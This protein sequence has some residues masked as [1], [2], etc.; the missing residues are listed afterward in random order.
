MA[1]TPM[2]KSKDEWRAELQGT[3]GIGEA[4]RLAEG[5]RRLDA[6]RQC[7]QLFVSPAPVLSQ[8]RINALLDGKELVVPG[9][10]L[11]EGFYLLRPFQIP[12]AKLPSAV[13]MRGIPTH[14]R[15]VFHQEL[16]TLSIELLITEAL[17]IDAMG[18]RLG[19]GSGYFDLACALLHRCGAMAE[20]ATIW[21]TAVSH[22][23]AQLPIDSWD[24]R[25]SG[26]VG[27]E[28]E[29]VFPPTEGMPDI[30]WQHLKRQQIKK[31]TPLWKEWERDQQGL[32]LLDGRDPKLPPAQPE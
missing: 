12:F 2:A 1:P 10:G 4:G 24:V 30:L 16:A 8:V 11:K 31:I 6:Y 13:S 20:A 14:G 29:I 9:P 3:E 19:D 26:L 15:L 22:R 21:A 23:P 5:V 17:A 32:A 28:G 18:N 27:P 25:M 7:R